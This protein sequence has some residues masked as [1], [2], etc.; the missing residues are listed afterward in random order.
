MSRNSKNAQRT[1]QK[2]QMKDGNGP[3]KTNPKHGKLNA[4]WQTTKP[5][6]Y[7]SWF[8]NHKA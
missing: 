4:W 8:H 3:A 7:S 2:H 6:S 5:K 1:K